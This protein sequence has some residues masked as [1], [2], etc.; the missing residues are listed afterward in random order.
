M[1]RQFSTV[2]GALVLVLALLTP[3]A[4]ADLVGANDPALLAGVDGFNLTRDT[5]SGLDWVDLTLTQG[6]DPAVVATQLSG[7]A[8]D[9]YRMASLPELVTLFQHGSGNMKPPSFNWYLKSWSWYHSTY[10]S[11]ADYEKAQTLIDFVGATHVYVGG[12]SYSPYIYNY[13]YGW[14]YAGS[15][16]RVCTV[17]TVTRPP[18][19]Y[20]Y[21]R[22]SWDIPPTQYQA[23]PFYRYATWLVRDTPTEVIPEP[24]TL[25]LLGAGLVVV[26]LHRRRRKRSS[27]AR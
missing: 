2:V 5:V 3:Q 22:S 18:G 21:Y 20:S 26:A 23:Y 11:A 16:S 10:G 4:Q 7:G 1:S 24:G 17:S 14:L 8:F 6:M 13:A 9:G 25:A 19:S 27:A 15:H 12:S